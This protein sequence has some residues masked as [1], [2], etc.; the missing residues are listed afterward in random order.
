MNKQNS[1]YSPFI[2]SLLLISG[3]IIGYSLSSNHSTYSQFGGFNEQ[4]KINEV[5]KL[6]Q[7]DYVDTVNEQKLI[8]NSLN[9]ILHNLDPHSTYI[10]SS[11]FQNIAEEMSGD[12]EGIGIQYRIIKDSLVVIMPI[13]GGPS[14]KKGIRAGDRI[15][16]VDDKNI[17]QIKITNDTVMRLLKGPKGSKVQLTIFRPSIKKFLKFTIKR[18]KIPVYS[19]DIAY[20]PKTTIG[21]IKINRFSATTYDEFVSKTEI[22]KAKGMKKLIIDLRDNGG[23]YL[24]AATNLCNDFLGDQA[25]IVS[26]IGKNR[27]KEIIKAN[28]ET[29]LQN[30][31]L[32]ILIN[33]YSASASEI[34]TGAIQDNDRGIIIGRQSF[35]KGLVQEQIEFRDKSAIRLTVARYY[36]PSGR[37]IQKSYAKGYKEYGTDLLKRYSNNELI[38]P[39]SIHFADSL[40]YYTKSGRLVYGGGGIMPDIFVPIDTNHLYTY[41]NKI[42]DQGLIYQYSFNYIDGKREKLI[43]KYKTP[44]SFIKNFTVS[45]KMISDI[46][47]LANKKGIPFE[48]ESFLFSK[49]QIQNRL[50]AFIGRGLFD[51]EAFYPIL[52]MQDKT[53]QKAIEEFEK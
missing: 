53:F 43:S 38:N 39:D 31:D 41:F 29:R 4:S 16:A 47:D 45:T 1:F 30:T 50:K 34:V 44:D 27:Q 21:Y 7:T 9:D 35:G 17:T 5:L 6:I 19:I 42:T 15:V 48:K 8:E 10:P 49:P 23:G 25:E 12:F 14:D 11:K 3:I 13:S 40:K 36:T 33:E 26:T 20:M 28:S 18:D 51:N 24:R 37:C 22:L 32:I 46:I 2:F 52:L